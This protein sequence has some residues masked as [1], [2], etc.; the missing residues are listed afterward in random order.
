M[1][2]KNIDFSQLETR[3]INKLMGFAQAYGDHL[4][5]RCLVC[6]AYYVDLQT[7]CEEKNDNEHMVMLTHGT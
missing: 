6:E 4:P 3:T 7:H 2:L 5:R 1:I